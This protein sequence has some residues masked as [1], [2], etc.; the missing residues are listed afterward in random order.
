MLS[1]GNRFVAI[2]G[3]KY[4]SFSPKKLWR[5]KKLSKSVLGY[6]KITTESTFSL[7]SSYQNVQIL[8]GFI[9]SFHNP[10]EILKKR[11]KD[12]KTNRKRDIE[13]Q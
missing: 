3:K 7:R 10:R 6:I 12:K 8:S 9:T 1:V 11:V 4:G 5:E 2:F 13:D